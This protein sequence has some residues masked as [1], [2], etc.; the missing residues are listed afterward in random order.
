MK[1]IESL[2]NRHFNNVA[3]K[4]TLGAILIYGILVILLSVLVIFGNDIMLK[5]IVNSVLGNVSFYIP[6]IIGIMPVIRYS[7]IV[8]EKNVLEG[9]T[10][11]SY[12][13]KFLEMLKIYTAMFLLFLCIAI[14]HKV[15]IQIIDNGYE[16]SRDIIFFAES[17]LAMVSF[18]IGLGMYTI[19]GGIM[20]NLGKFNIT[21][22]ILI[23]GIIFY[24]NSNIF[25][26]IDVF[27]GQKMINTYLMTG[28]MSGKYGY[29][30][31]IIFNIIFN[32]IFVKFILKNI[33]K[34]DT[35]KLGI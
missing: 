14:I 12:K 30:V 8:L 15:L 27:V 18:S 29:L 20:K 11:K 22:G 10:A 25:S 34:I 17:Y 2:F 4:V 31:K 24:M 16:N 13:E 7:Q 32:F 3:D 21:T 6:W 5:S 19:C 28:L 26:L 23:T 9:I 35:R 33:N 1:K